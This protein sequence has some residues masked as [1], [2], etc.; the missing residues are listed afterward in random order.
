MQECKKS[1]GKRENKKQ[2][3]KKKEMGLTDIIYTNTLAFVLFLLFFPF[4]ITPSI[5]FHRTEP[6]LFIHFIDFRNFSG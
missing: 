2:D 4:S 6:S 3:E 1:R 5:P